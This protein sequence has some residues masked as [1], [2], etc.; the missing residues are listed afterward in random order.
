MSANACFNA[1][2]IAFELPDSK[3]TPDFKV[4]EEIAEAA[5]ILSD[6]EGI[7]GFEW[8]DQK[9]DYETFCHVIAGH[10]LVRAHTSR[11]PAF[12]WELWFAERLK[13]PSAPW[14]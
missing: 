6:Y 13:I 1:A 5:K 11:D 4:F 8:Q 3:E 2:R 14:P 10:A 12:T 7:P 9:G